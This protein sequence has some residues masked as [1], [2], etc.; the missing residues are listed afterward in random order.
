M[1]CRK[2]TSRHG[3][4][5]QTAMTLI[6]VMVA[7]AAGI[8]LLAAVATGWAFTAR[9]FVAIGNYTDMDQ[10][11][12]NCLDVM[13]R[14]IRGASSLK[15]YTT[16]KITLAKPDGTTFTYLFNPNT[17][18][19]SRQQG[20]SS[21][22]LLEQCEYAVFSVSQRNITNGFV[23]YSTADQPGVTKL[24][25]VSWKCSRKILGSKVNT[26]NVQTAKIVLRN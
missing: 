7:F 17:K 19:L 18:T 22:I 12:Q 23:F 1:N 24:V 9:S 4:A 21:T 2:S 14:E 13:S 15:F 11:S 26:E 6:E 25:D 16:N 3:R 5:Q 10:A 8:L 20:S